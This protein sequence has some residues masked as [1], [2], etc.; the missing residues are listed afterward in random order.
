MRKFLDKHFRVFSILPMLIIILAVIVYPICY[1][2]YLSF[3]DTNNFNLISGLA[4][5]V[6]LENYIRHFQDK[7]FITAMW[8]T[9]YFTIV[10][11][12]LSTVLGILLAYTIY[13]LKRGYKN[14]MVAC[15]LLPTLISETA[16]ALIFRPM[17]DFST[18]IINYLITSIGLPGIN[19][20]GDATIAQWV[21]M[22]LNIWQWTPYMFIFMLSGIESLD[23]AYFEVARIDGASKLEILWHVILPMITPVLLV[24]VFFRVTNSLRAFD[25]IYM[26]TGGGPGF[27][28]DTITSYI[29]RVG[30]LRMEFGYSSAGGVIMLLFTALI[31]AIALKFMYENNQ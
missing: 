5:W 24:A 9:L 30:I 13:P 2:F 11:V 31:G 4:E 15:I 8:N 20:L 28:T 27:A 26:L 3:T 22:L 14:L 18:G 6:G 16:C 29:Q 17:L 23:T 7:A 25:K 10:S 12:G 1:L 21:I 19:F